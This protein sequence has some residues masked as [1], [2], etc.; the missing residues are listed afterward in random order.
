MDHLNNCPDTDTDS[1]SP[2]KSESAR[3]DFRVQFKAG[4]THLVSSF[5]AVTEQEANAEEEQL[6]FSGSSLLPIARKISGSFSSVASNDD[7]HRCVGTPKR[8]FDLA[9]QS[10]LSDLTTLHNSKSQPCFLSPGKNCIERKHISTP[11]LNH[12]VQAHSDEREAISTLQ[13]S[14]K[15]RSF[16]AVQLRMLQCK[17]GAKNSQKKELVSVPS[18]RK[19]F[20]MQTKFQN[21]YPLD[22]KIYL[23]L[24]V[25]Q[26]TVKTIETQFP[27]ET[28]VDELASAQTQGSSYQDSCWEFGETDT[29]FKTEFSTNHVQGA[30]SG[31]LPEKQSSTPLNF[32]SSPGTRTHSTHS[33]D[34]F[35]S[36][37]EHTL[38]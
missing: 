26:P 8:L 17:D 20:L 34:T 12:H 21:Y 11:S 22:H 5:L 2:S 13:E 36:F 3:P 9:L 30:Q 32:N 7:K 38:Y 19:Q 4:P 6:S 18:R 24:K 10:V 16:D 33:A 31:L 1:D 28:Q 27:N 35:L 23:R 15:A 29:T 37:S 14:K 25:T